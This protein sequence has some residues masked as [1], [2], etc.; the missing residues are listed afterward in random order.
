MVTIISK[1]LL[2]NYRIFKFILFKRNANGVDSYEL[3][4]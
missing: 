2:V 3:K 4:A 1:L